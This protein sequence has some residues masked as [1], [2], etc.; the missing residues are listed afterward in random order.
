MNKVGPGLSNYKNRIYPL[1]FTNVQNTGL[2]TKSCVYRIHMRQL[3]QFLTS[4]I[5]TYPHCYTVIAVFPLMKTIINNTQY[6]GK[7]VFVTIH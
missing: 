6:A 7:L 5:S 2:Q 3:K 4:Q 1:G